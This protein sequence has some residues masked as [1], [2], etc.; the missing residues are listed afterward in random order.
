MNIVMLDTDTLGNDLDFSIYE[1][2]GNV[3][4]YGMTLAELAAERVK[5]ADIVIVNKVKL[6]AKNLGG[7]DKLKL[8][9][10][11]A[12]GFDNID[13]EYCRANGIAVCNVKGYST[14]SVA[15]LT[16]TMA[17][18]LVMHTAVFDRYVKDKSYTGSGVQ[19]CLTPIFHEMSQLTWG[20][21]GMG[22]IGMETARIA[23][24][25]GAE[26]IAY[27]RTRRGDFV[28][29]DIDD[30]C[31]RSDIIS[32]HLPL[33]DETRNLISREKIA[34]MK[35]DSVFINVSRGAVADEAALAEAV[36]E[37]RIGG[38]GI[39]VYSEEPLSENSPYN[40]ILDCDNVILTPHMAWGA[41]EA[42]VRCMEEISMN[43]KAFLNGG[44]KRNRVV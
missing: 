14:A 38:I 5:N 9:C 37:K 42:R 10:V 2:Y 22:H 6:N 20:I 24:A 18:S 3:T 36:S 23:Q 16:V 41:Y 17:L 21:I 1:K 15:Q 39:D 35:K 28:Y 12:T 27:N 44:E 43:I 4:K 11:T 31:R 32:V 34:L 7:A 33:N 19:N 30:L 26:V 13:L 40:R 29:T 25:L 8:I